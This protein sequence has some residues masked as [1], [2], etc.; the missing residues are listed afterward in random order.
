MM[1]PADVSLL[2]DKNFAKYVNEFAKDQ[3][4][5][6]DAFAKAYQKLVELGNH[7]L[8]DSPK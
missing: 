2:L 4:A 5:F 6:H 7:E 3:K 1:L 8:N